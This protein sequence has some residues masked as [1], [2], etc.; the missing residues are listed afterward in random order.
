M[1]AAFGKYLHAFLNILLWKSHYSTLFTPQQKC[2]WYRQ[3]FYSRLIMGHLKKRT[4]L[5]D[6]GNERTFLQKSPDD[7]S[8][9][10]TFDA[11]SVIEW[12]PHVIAVE[13]NGFNDSSLKVCESVFTVRKRSWGLINVLDET[14]LIILMRANERSSEIWFHLVGSSLESVERRVKTGHTVLVKLSPY[15]GVGSMSKISYRNWR[16]EGAQYVSRYRDL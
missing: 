15:Y 13:P 6:I 10:N 14:P 12:I 1:C 11:V 4:S 5:T 16:Y 8:G 3:A 7:S 9:V 2:L